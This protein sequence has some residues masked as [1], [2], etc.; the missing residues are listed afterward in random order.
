MPSEWPIWRPKWQPRSLSEKQVLKGILGSA[1]IVCMALSAETFRDPNRQHT[2]VVFSGPHVWNWKT[3]QGRSEIHHVIVLTDKTLFIVRDITEDIARKLVMAAPEGDQAVVAR[4]A[5]S[6]RRY[7]LPVT[8]LL[9]VSWVA[10]QCNALIHTSTGRAVEVDFPTSGLT[11]EVCAQVA[12]SLGAGERR[13][14]DLGRAEKSNV[15]LL[16][17]VSAIGVG[18]GA[19]ALE[20]LVIDPA[21]P[22]ELLWGACGALV[23][24][25][26]L[27]AYQTLSKK[28]ERISMT[29]T[30]PSL[31][32]QTL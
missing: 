31:R 32:Q 8:D 15:A 28:T 1:V 13:V 16:P 23:G 2:P 11:Q 25:A 22:G 17:F 20:R 27:L 3:K 9:E 7:S 24:S 29:I 21:I 4:S 18:I 10:D 14:T 19:S 12:K 30:R 26:A 6:N 5:P